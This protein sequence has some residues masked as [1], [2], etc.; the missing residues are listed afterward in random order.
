MART[1]DVRR[2]GLAVGLIASLSVAVFYAV[3]DILAARGGLY[4]INLLGKAVFRGVRD[5]VVLQY[6]VL[7][8]AGAMLLYTGLH[9][10]LSLI[11][12]LIVTRLI[13]E[14][15]QQPSRARLVLLIIVA[16]FFVT[17]FAVGSL[18]SSMR[19]LLPW[20]SIVVAN[21]LAVALAGAYLLSRHPGL[22]RRLAP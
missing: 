5:P 4:T 10:V 19:P 18:S 9:L 14:A 15:E 22:M 2:E 16:G 3:F 17:V 6:P 13:A 7:P 12:G 8:D 11:I 20:W 21:G 1:V